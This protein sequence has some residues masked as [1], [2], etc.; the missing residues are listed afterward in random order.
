MKKSLKKTIKLI[1]NND[2]IDEKIVRIKKD[3]SLGIFKDIK[4]YI[5]KDTKPNIDKDTK[6]NINKDT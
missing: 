4:L 1:N 2:S 3:N 5:N 6:P